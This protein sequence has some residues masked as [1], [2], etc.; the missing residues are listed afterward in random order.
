MRGFARERVWF[1]DVGLCVAHIRVDARNGLEMKIS[2][3]I[4]YQKMAGK[5]CMWKLQQITTNQEG[6]ESHLR[7]LK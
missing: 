7:K 4:V 1:L 3:S 2:R 5:I 6:T